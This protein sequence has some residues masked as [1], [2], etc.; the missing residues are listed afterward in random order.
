MTGGTR[1][2]PSCPAG[3]RG[4]GASARATSLRAASAGEGS[5]RA[6]R[7]RPA[8]PID[9]RRRAATPAPNRAPTPARTPARTPESGPEHLPIAWR[10]GGRCQPSARAPARRRPGRRL[11]HSVGRAVEAEDGREWTV[12]GAAVPSSPAGARATVGAGRSRGSGGHVEM[13]SASASR[14]MPRRWA[15]PPRCP[16]SRSS[17]RPASRSWAGADRGG[18][19]ADEREHAGRPRVAPGRGIDLLGGAGLARDVVAGDGRVVAGAV[20]RPRSIMI[21]VRVRAGLR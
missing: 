7:W 18:H 9:C 16:T 12:P 4:G 5:G 1:R 3:P 13:R 14:P 10:T 6:G 20:A 8:G 11:G 17:A 2:A 15:R 21:S 19:E